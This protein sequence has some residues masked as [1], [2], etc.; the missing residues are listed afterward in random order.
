M[1]LDRGNETTTQLLTLLNVSATKGG[2][3]KWVPDE[4]KPKARLNKRRVVLVDKP[5]V[6][7]VE[8]VEEKDVGIPEAS[9]DVAKGE[10]E[11]TTA[12]ISAEVEDETQGTH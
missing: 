12:T 2:K 1:G 10:L 5:T 9:S 6:T 4:E 8:R 11:E 7:I 3:R